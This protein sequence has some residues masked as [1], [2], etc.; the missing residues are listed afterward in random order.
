MA[1]IKNSGINFDKIKEYIDQ[2]DA[3]KLASK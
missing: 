1:S 3:I 2:A